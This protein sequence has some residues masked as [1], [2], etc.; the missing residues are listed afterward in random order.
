MAP[1]QWSLI[2]MFM[3]L[4]MSLPGVLNLLEKLAVDMMLD[5]LVFTVDSDS[6]VSIFG[7]VLVVKDL[8][9]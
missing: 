4:S 6:I 3:L 8:V 2:L 9:F 7:G 1:I 5:D